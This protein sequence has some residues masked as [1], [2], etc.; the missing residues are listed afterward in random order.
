MEAFLLHNR[1]SHIKSPV[2]QQ[3]TEIVI[4]NLRVSAIIMRNP[5]FLKLIYHY[6][7]EELKKQ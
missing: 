7:K 1:K 5:S 6:S 4:S 3:H 2:M